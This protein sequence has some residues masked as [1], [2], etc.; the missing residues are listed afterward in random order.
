VSL[1]IHFHDQNESFIGAIKSK[2][3]QQNTGFHLN[4]ENSKA[5]NNRVRWA[6]LAMQTCILIW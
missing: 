4:T 6:S 2:V 3:G 5:A 1:K